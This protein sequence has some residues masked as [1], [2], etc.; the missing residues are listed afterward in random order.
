MAS[1]TLLR[2]DLGLGDREIQEPG[3]PAIFAAA[4]VAC[5][6]VLL[7]RCPVARMIPLDYDE[8]VF[9]GDVT[10][11]WFPM[12]HTLFKTLARV[13]GL[14]TGD[15]Y[16]GFI[17]LD[18]ISSA[19]ALVSLWWW[20]RA[21]APPATAAAAALMLAV[22]PDF[23]A[24][25][26]VAG[27]YTAIVAVGSFLLGVAIRGH[28]R[29]EPWHPLAAAV[30]LA[31]GTGYRPD[32]GIFWLPVFLVILWQHRW[33]RA[34]IAGI[35]FGL[36]NLAWASAMIAEVGGWE[37]YRA[38]SAQFAHSAGALNSYWNLGFFDGP[39]RY[40]VKLAM[41]LIWTLGPALLFVPR[42]VIRLR[43][44]DS[45]RFLAFLLVLSVV[46]A[47]LFHLLIHFGVAGYCFHYVP[48]IMALVVL[49]IGRE[50]SVESGATIPRGDRAV[51]R[52][53]G[54]AAILAA[55][56]WFYPTD[57]SAPGWR[58]DFD[59]AFCRLTRNG[60][61][62]PTPKVSPTMWRTANSIEPDGTPAQSVE[63]DNAGGR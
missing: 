21:I 62:T 9:L 10:A 57:F 55:L 33:K 54:I 47:L 23:W 36:M 46:P 61:N 56:F 63:S 11:R 27:N 48:A 20:L 37:Q 3:V 42:G 39:L 35:A 52:L 5:A 31:A 18:M 19:F 7:T 8:F 26:A 51:P 6:F 45:G 22:G 1:W 50:R 43:G 13:F 58:G 29:L 16:R 15:F 34:I 2:S 4:G 28:R 17:A 38:T 60:I 14:L 25:G 53:I 32:I 44:V 41:A 24:Y 12:H 59:L 40:G 49:G 30:V